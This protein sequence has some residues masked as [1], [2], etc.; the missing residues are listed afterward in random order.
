M[1]TEV[2][3]RGRADRVWQ[4]LAWRVARAWRRVSRLASLSRILLARRLGVLEA[5]PAAPQHLPDPDLSNALQARI[6]CA[7]MDVHNQPADLFAAL[8]RL[9]GRAGGGL[10][11]WRQR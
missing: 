7:L 8:A 3:G 5:L 1:L 4:A 6:R 9:I 10:R 11:H 2:A